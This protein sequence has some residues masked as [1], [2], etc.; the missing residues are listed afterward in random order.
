MGPNP[1][2]LIGLR[3]GEVRDRL[4]G[5][6]RR[7]G[8]ETDVVDDVRQTMALLRI[9]PFEASFL[10]DGWVAPDGGTVWR[11]VHQIVGRRLVLMVWERRNVLWFEALR[12]GVGA[13]LPLPPEEASVRAAL[14]AVLRPGRLPGAR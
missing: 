11:V 8:F 1:S 13:V 6:V 3:A 10:E 9:R 4:V 14:E 5:W 12:A 2:V 7:Q